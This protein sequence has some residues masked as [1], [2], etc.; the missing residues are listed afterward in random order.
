[1][2]RLVVFLFCFC[3]SEAF[4]QTPSAGNQSEYVTIWRVTR[5]DF[6][7]QDFPSNVLTG[8]LDSS[9]SK[10][11]IIGKGETV[12][13]KLRDLFN[14]SETWT[15]AVYSTVLAEVSR[16]NPDLDFFNLKPGTPVVVPELPVTGKSNPGNNPADRAPNLLS[17]RAADN[18]TWSE[19][20]AR[21][22]G[23]RPQ[24]KANAPAAQSE[25]QYFR[26]PAAV[27]KTY[28]DI[29][30]K[31]GLAAGKFGQSGKVRVALSDEAPNTS[32][33]DKVLPQALA[34]A[35]KSALANA[36]QDSPRP[37]VIVLDD[38][39]PDSASFN[40]AK[41]FIL[42]A[43]ASIRSAFSLGPSPYTD[44]LNALQTITSNPQ[45][46]LY[47]NLQVHSAL[48]HSALDEFSG[49][50]PNNTVSL[51]Y[52]PLAGTQYEVIPIIREILYLGQILKICNPSAGAKFSASLEQRK[53]AA[54]M[55]EQIL[56]DDSS[57]VATPLQVVSGTQV[58]LNT[59]AMYLE[60]LSIVL[61]HFS[62]VSRRPHILSFSWTAPDLQYETYFEPGAYGWKL[63]AAGNGTSG[64]SANILRPPILQF[65]YRGLDPKDFLVVANSTGT[66]SDCP[67]NTFDDPPEVK[68]VGLAF[69]GNINS[70]VCGTSF[71]T[72]RVAW[73]LAAREV[74]LGKKIKPGDT[75][76]MDAW[77]SSKES[78]IFQLQGQSP[79]FIE[80]Y[81]LDIGKLLNISS[82]N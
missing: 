14:V 30:K 26:L 36:P 32:Q 24:V 76:A 58:F 29:L 75:G 69:P 47:P 10:Q 31:L 79:N 15:P 82:A 53:S 1:M 27:A 78:F 45:I 18:Y 80:R 46:P 22:V 34:N 43:S 55:V 64:Q 56:R 17:A 61:K 5:N 9:P 60:S 71:S 81:S 50:D 6:H 77:I 68:I 40:S 19:Q 21:F 74:L 38:S 3:S 8:I 62:D 2:R 11:V 13:Q 33:V 4:G 41:Q 44:Q 37:V 35:I 67:T 48:I 51:V 23:D 54:D 66:A 73:L 20:L 59:D 72:P 12:S 39:I 52:L 63:S 42:D 57:L 70:S 49:L 65:A 25:L 28:I 16:L 7:S